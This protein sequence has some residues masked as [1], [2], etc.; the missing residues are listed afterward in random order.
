MI[1]MRYVGRKGPL[2]LNNRRLQSIYTIEGPGAEVDFRD[3]DARLLLTENPH[4]FRVVGVVATT[5][6]A[7]A[8]APLAAKPPVDP[9]PPVDP[10]TEASAREILERSEGGP[11][12]TLGGDGEEGPDPS[13]TP[14]GPPEPGPVHYERATLA[15]LTEMTV[16]TL[17]EYVQDRQLGITFGSREK[18]N[19]I[20]AKIIQAETEREA[21]APKG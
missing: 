19:E 11:V 8:P 7:A 13:E 3:E 5:M 20:I 12:D 1:R 17:L 21:A 14:A 10:E 2:V 6:P 9:A 16:A 18:K 15:D 4:M